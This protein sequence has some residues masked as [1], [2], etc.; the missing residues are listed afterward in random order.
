[1]DSPLTFSAKD[2][3]SQ[4]KYFYNINGFS[5]NGVEWLDFIFLL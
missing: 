2:F 1:M 3:L 5:L 4:I